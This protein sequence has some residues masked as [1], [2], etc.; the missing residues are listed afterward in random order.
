[1]NPIENYILNTTVKCKE[2]IIIEKSTNELYVDKKCL[3][4]KININVQVF[5]Q[6]Y[7]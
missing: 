6:I 2:N 5:F 7:F 1:M 4:K 3:F